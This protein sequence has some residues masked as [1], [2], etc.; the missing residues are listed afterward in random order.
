[1]T[2]VILKTS[3]TE[4]WSKHKTANS[5]PKLFLGCHGSVSEIVRDSETGRNV[6]KGDTGS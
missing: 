2:T 3:A 6:D 5:L 1:M 4:E